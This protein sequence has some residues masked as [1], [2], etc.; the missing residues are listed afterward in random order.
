M[1]IV[2][3]VM[4]PLAVQW[5]VRMAGETEPD[6]AATGRHAARPDFASEA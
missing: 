5:G 2:M 6:P 1:I 4:G 3:E